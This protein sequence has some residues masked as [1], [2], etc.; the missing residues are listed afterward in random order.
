MGAADAARETKRLQRIRWAG[1]SICN[2]EA[3][4]CVIIH[5]SGYSRARACVRLR[6][7]CQHSRAAAGYNLTW[8]LTCQRRAAAWPHHLCPLWLPHT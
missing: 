1:L 3:H 7:P 2:R 5:T 4:G 8:K 6:P